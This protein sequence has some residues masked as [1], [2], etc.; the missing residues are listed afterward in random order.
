MK[1][2]IK[3]VSFIRNL[4]IKRKLVLIAMSTSLIG[5]LVAGLAFSL[6]DRYRVKRDL[7]QDISVQAMLIADRSTAALLF[8]D[9]RLAEENLAALRVKPA[10]KSASILNEK[11]SVFASYKA[12]NLYPS[13]T[14][15]IEKAP[16]HKFE[17]DKLLV[18]EP[19][20]LEGKQ[21]GSVF[22]CAGLEQL[23]LLWRNY[24]LLSA[25]IILFAGITAFFLSSRLQRLVSEPISNLTRIARVVATDKDYS[26]RAVKDS[27]D[28]LGV[29]VQ[30]F[31]TMLETIEDQ[32]SELMDSNR[33]LEQRVAERTHELQEAMERAE[34]ADRLKS[35]FLATMSHELR[36]PLNSIIGFTGILLQELGGPI[37]DEQ[38]K[39]LTMVKNSASHLLS[40]ISDVLDISKIEAGQLKVS[41]EPFNLRESVEKVTLSIRP[42]VEKKGIGLSIDIATD[43]GTVINDIRR[44]EQILLNLLSN[45]VKFT[46]DGKISV[47]CV[48]DGSVFVTSVTD[49]GIGIKDDELERLFKPFYQIDTGLSR[50]YEGTGLGLSIC[51]RLVELMGGE[52]GVRSELGVGST[53]WF[54]L[55]IGSHEDST[56]IKPTPSDNS[57]TLELNV[58]Q[59][60]TPS[61]HQVSDYAATTVDNTELAIV[62]RS[63]AALLRD[64]DASAGDLLIANRA[65]LMKVFPREFAVIEGAIRRFDYEAALTALEAVL[66]QVDPSDRRGPDSHD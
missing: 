37:N 1:T 14:A 30:S 46:E 39:Q 41:M 45:A 22:I 43:V 11:G 18:L 62:C 33:R 42:L 4:P 27:D 64:D 15:P 44:V 59:A 55:P 58:P 36:T 63:L 6:Y 19:V 31:N 53:F 54:T 35:A 32:N 34:M 47:R 16:W 60:N 38:A 61:Q 17:D 23:N 3:T 26:A 65:L 10:V 13:S 56:A 21:I 7:L 25:V 28:E 20:L 50:K 57:T 29:L 52:I 49:T 2:L 12:S 40:L 8:D 9:A 5:L 24:L 51:K 66:K 48:R